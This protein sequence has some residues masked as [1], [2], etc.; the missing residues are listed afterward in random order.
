MGFVVEHTYGAAH[1]VDCVFHNRQSEPGASNLARAS[2]VYAVEAFKQVRQ[3][4]VF[5]SASVVVEC[6]PVFPVVLSYQGEAAHGASRVEVGVAYEVGH[7]SEQQIVI[8]HYITLRRHIVSE[9]Q[10]CRGLDIAELALYIGKQLVE[11]YFFELLP[12]SS[13]FEAGD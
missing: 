7:H 11:V 5:H 8:A 9:S 6:K 10:R 13:L 12:L 1:D 4:L 3:M 2:F